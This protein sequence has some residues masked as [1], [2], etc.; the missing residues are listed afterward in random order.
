MTLGQSRAQG[1]KTALLMQVKAAIKKI[2]RPPFLIDVLLN[3]RTFKKALINNQV[4]IL[5]SI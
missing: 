1:E 4:S 3:L 5:F 2:D